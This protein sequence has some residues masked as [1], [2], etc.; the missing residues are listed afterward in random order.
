[1]QYVCL[2]CVCV[3]VWSGL[4]CL[5]FGVRFSAACEKNL[6]T[7][8]NAKRIRNAA[9]FSM[10]MKRRWALQ[11]EKGVRVSCGQIGNGDDVAAVA[12]AAAAKRVHVDTLIPS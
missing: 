3:Y 7:E 12:A 10:V 8:K 4:V 1:M 11:L 5:P 2:R 9:E 6:Y